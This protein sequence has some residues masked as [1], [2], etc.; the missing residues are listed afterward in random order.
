MVTEASSGTLM[1]D[2]SLRGFGLTA[3][4]PT[5]FLAYILP[6]ML[7]RL[8]ALP[9]GVGLTEAGM[10]GFLASTAGIDADIAAV[11]A[12][13]FRVGTVFFQALLGALVYFFGLEGRGRESGLGGKTCL[14]SAEKS[15]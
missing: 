12:A 13:V 15:G 5:L 11:A 7:G 8:S 4:Y 1:L 14:A 3:S 6:A 2:L 9:A 10:V